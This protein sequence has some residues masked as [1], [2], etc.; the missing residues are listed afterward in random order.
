MSDKAAKPGPNSKPAAPPPGD[1]PLPDV[2]AFARN[3]AEVGKKSQKLVMDYLATRDGPKGVQVVDPLNVGQA[4]VDLTTRMMHDPRQVM[5][6]QAKLWAGHLKLWQNTTKRLLWG[7][8]VEPVVPTPQGDKRFK[9]PDWQKNQ[10]FDFIKQSYLLTADWLQD[11][12][13]TVEGLDA[14]T[15]KKINFYTKQFVDAMSPSNFILTN[16]EVLKETLRTNGENLVRG[17]THVI[18]DLERGKGKLQIRQVDDSK[19][20]VGENLATTPGKVV[21]QNDLMQLLQYSPTTDEV[22]ERPLLIIPPWINKFYILDLKPENSFIRWA[23][24]QGYS[25]FVVS[26]V[27]PDKRLSQKAFDDYLTEGFYPALQATQDATGSDKVNVIGYCI[28]GTLTT[29]GLAHMAARGDDRI[30]S[31]TFFTSQV[32]F[33][34][35]GDLTV[36]ID[37]QQLASME[38]QMK[39]QGGYLDGEAMAT[40]FN[41]LRSND[42]IWSF[43]VNNYLLGR[44]PLAFDL[45]YWNSDATR[46]P[47]AMHLQYLRECYRDNLLAQGKMKLANVKLDLK[48]ITVPVFLQSSK[49]DHIAPAKS[50]YK[51]TK[52]FSGPTEFMMAGSGH[53]AGVINPPSAKKYQFWTNTGTPPTLDAWRAGATETPGSWWHYWD[54]WLAPKSGGKVKARIPG[55]AKLRV[56]EDAP[57]SYVKM[58]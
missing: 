49:E 41:M 25:V 39:K 19:F 18:E 26:W 10:I 29:A 42:L 11:T 28:G 46:M 7:D 30:T 51:A 24:A 57:G 15:R 58:K 4:F 44:D 55:D 53:I 14:P 37:D 5:E 36:F 56:I 35:A 16:P 48:K 12:V 38:A 20:K 40:T 23:V 21:F 8:D 32:D 9:D 6:A 54:A 3:M 17:L 47:I 13:D 43:V 1:F 22:Y 34:E 50:V 45:L 52:A 31:A 27:N 2:S 33:T